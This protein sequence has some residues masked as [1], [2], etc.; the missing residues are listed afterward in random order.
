MNDVDCMVVGAGVIGLAVGREL[1]H[2]GRQVIIL[3]QERRI[4][5]HTSSRN[6]EVVHAGIYYPTNSLKARLC[7]AGRELLQRYCTERNIVLRTCGKFIVATSTSQL[8]ELH[9]LE[10]QAKSNGVS[11][12][13]WRDGAQAAREEPVLNCVA[14]LW[15]PLTSVID[16][17]AYLLSL[18]ADAESYGTEIA[19]GSAVSSL[20]P[21]TQGIE[22]CINDEAAP[23]AR[24]K[25]LVNC[26]GLDAHRVAASITGFPRAHIPQIYF[27]KGSYF[28][29]AGAAPFR[30]LIYPVPDAGGLGIH[31]CI[32]LNGCARFGPDLEWVQARDYAVDPTRDK[33]FIDAI[34]RYWPNISNRT[35]T[36][37]YAGIRATLSGPGRPPADFCLSGPSQHG[38]SGVLNL[39]GIDSPG[40]TAS[41]ALATQVAE[42]AIAAL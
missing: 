30:R 40:L 34:R 12:L 32:D 11:D 13:E 20:R 37:A 5:L 8:S 22:V 33:V 35:L 3:E 23:V 28:A 24:A 16:S 25:I 36:P 7:V 6:S 17:Q 10:L 18:L 2:R 9:A 14:A 41:L 27:A 42:M 38:V 31:M 21:T 15:S 19:Y 4:G 1:A 29:L 39:F 26:A